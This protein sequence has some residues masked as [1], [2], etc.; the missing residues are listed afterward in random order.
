M[1][2]TV[3][4]IQGMTCGHCV[5]H[6]TKALK[7]VPGVKD[8]VVDLSRAEAMVTHDGSFV[9]GTVKKAVEDAG[10]RLAKA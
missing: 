1:S 7:E 10:Y 8:A 3:F 4:H 2:T 5:A 6:V 9:V